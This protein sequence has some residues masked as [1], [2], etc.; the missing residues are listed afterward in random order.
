M[1]SV[2]NNCAPGLVPLMSSPC[3]QAIQNIYHQ[4][5]EVKFAIHVCTEFEVYI[6]GESLDG[7]KI[8]KLN[9]ISAL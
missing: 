3:L 7:V 5:L 4:V 1:S 2:N 6:Y 9:K 8:F